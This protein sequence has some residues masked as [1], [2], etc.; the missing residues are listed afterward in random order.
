MNKQLRYLENVGLPPFTL[1]SSGESVGFCLVLTS[2]RLHGCS[3][4]ASSD[5][6]WQKQCHTVTRAFE[7]L[8]QPEL[9]SVTFPICISA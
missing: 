5:T 7:Q 3:R 2:T 9:I 6:W 1:H 4:C 8:C